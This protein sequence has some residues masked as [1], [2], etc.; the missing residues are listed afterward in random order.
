MR[1]RLP[2]APSTDISESAVASAGIDFDGDLLI[3]GLIELHTDHLE[4]H[5]RP[6][7]KVSWPAL[8]ALLAFDAQVAASGITTVYDCLRAGNDEDYAADTGEIETVTATIASAQAQGLLRAQHR[9]HVRCE[10]C[11]NDVLA[12]LD[13]V[14]ALETVSLISLMDHTPGA[15]QFVKLDAWRTYYGGKSGRSREELDRLIDLKHTLF[16]RNYK[17]HRK[18]L[19]SIAR[20]RGVVAQVTTM[21]RRSMC[22]NQ[23][24][25]ALRSLNSRRHSKLRG[26]RLCRHYGDDGRSQC[27]S[28]WLALWQRRRRDAGA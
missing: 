27:R 5:L 24:R 9:L 12:E 4:T 22:Q 10:I 21:Q 15:R 1:Y 8:S 20:E 26:S 23:S 16:A 2:T 18:A 19:V 6:R 11:A 13:R 3:P 25:T 7:P 17:T 28:R 14:L